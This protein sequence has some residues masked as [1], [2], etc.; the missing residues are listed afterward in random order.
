MYERTS[1][2][3]YRQSLKELYDEFEYG[4]VKI[5]RLVNHVTDNGMNLAANQLQAPKKGVQ[6]S[7][8]FL[9]V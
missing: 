6:C 5:E 9:N 1:T 8:F 2:H 4:M 3:E 7:D